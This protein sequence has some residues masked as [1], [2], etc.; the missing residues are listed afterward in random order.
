M[1]RR[2][3]AGATLAAAGCL[4]LLG[5]AASAAPRDPSGVYLTEDGRARVRLEKCGP[6]QENVCGYVVWLKQPNGDTGQPRRDL[7]NAERA[8]TARLLL[9]HQLILGLEPN[10]DQRYAGL[11]YNSEDG[12]KY[13]VNVWLDSPTE[14][15]VKGCLLAILCAT[16][17]WAKTSDVVPGQ[18]VAATGKPGGPQP[19]SEWAIEQASAT[20]PATAQRRDAGKPKP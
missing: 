13:E 10:G 16:Q 15:K 4:A 19:D 1:G 17:T 2:I 12:R 5:G 20:A 9:G 18:L 8:K 11:I 14:L 7:K 6:T 3:V